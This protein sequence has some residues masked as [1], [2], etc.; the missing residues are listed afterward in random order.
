[1]LALV[2]LLVQQALTSRYY[3]GFD[4][5]QNLPRLAGVERGREVNHALVIVSL[6]PVV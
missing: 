4:E 5:K 1:M 6:L 3:A 2:P